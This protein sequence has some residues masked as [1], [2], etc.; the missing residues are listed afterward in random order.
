LESVGAEE[1]RDCCEF[2]AAKWDDAYGQIFEVR[3]ESPGKYGEEE[4]FGDAFDDDESAAEEERGFGD[5]EKSTEL[6][7]LGVINRQCREVG[8]FGP[9]RSGVDDGEVREWYVCSYGWAV[10]G[11]DGLDLLFIEL[12][13]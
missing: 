11:D 12:L 5:V 6:R 10:A 3:A 2:H 7:A 9:S 13:A 8:C 4:C 1:L